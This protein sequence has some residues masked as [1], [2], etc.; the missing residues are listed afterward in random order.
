MIIETF[1]TAQAGTGMSLTYFAGLRPRAGRNGGL[2][3]DGCRSARKE[4]SVG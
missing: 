4:D 1:A 2:P 3:T